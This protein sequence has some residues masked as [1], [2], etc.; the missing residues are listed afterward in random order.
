MLKSGAA[1]TVVGLVAVLLLRSGSYVV[2][3]AVTIFVT[4]GNA[5]SATATLSVITAFALTF[6]LPGFVQVTCCPTAAQV[7]PVPPAEL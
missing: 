3:V 5:A 6:K 4:D 2:L 7:Q 1:F